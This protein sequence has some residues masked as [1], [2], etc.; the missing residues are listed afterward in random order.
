MTFIDWDI[1]NFNI[2]LLDYDVV[3]IGIRTLSTIKKFFIYHFKPV[4][5]FLTGQIQLIFNSH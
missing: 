3:N 4:K 2:K 5:P 1:F